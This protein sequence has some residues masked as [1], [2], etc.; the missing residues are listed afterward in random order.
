M[1]IVT[2]PG[3]VPPPVVNGNGSIP[4]N[5]LEGVAELDASKLKI[6]RC[7]SDKLKAIPPPESL[8]FGQI[9]TDYMLTVSYDPESGWS[10]P[11][12]KPYGPLVLDPISSCFQYCPNVFEGMKAY[13]GP[14]GK[15][16][17]FRPEMNMA[18]MKK[19]IERVA[20]PSLDTNELLKLI[21]ILVQ[22][23]SRWIPTLKGYSLYVRPTMIGTRPSLGVA[24]S[25]HALLYIVCSPTGPY[26]RTGPKALSILAVG[27]HVRSWPGGTGQY[28]L[29]LNYAPTFMPQREAAQLGY[30]QILWLFGDDAQ[31]TE[32]G[33]MNFF[34]VVKRDDGD[35]DVITPALDGTIL[36]GVT[37]DS[38]LSLLA[39]HPS[40]TSLPNIP[41]TLKL[42][43][44]ERKVTM[45]ELVAWANDGKLVESFGVGT[46]VIVGGI[47]RIGYQGKDVVFPKY[48]G[49]LG[50]IGAALY[51]R[52]TD[53]QEGRVEWEHWSAVCE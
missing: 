25:D 7:D 44:H 5:L 43:A 16:R 18:R 15:P 42:Y 40:K 29:S 10:A 53:I 35:L 6:T 22:L 31:I 32:A 19:S 51:Q 48:E 26:F 28:K 49:G 50:P 24:A 33:A 20:L 14:D 2:N 45:S 30:E 39:A 1:T 23:E 17:L 21:K 4:H 9:T 34:V 36:P 11:E 27:E 38:T 13:M 41:N 8:V 12:I 46:A 37:R 47:G 3:P 52:I